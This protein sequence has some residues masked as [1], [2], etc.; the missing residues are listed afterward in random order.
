MNCSEALLDA[1][2]K[3]AFEIGLK[4]LRKKNRRSLLKCWRVEMHLLLLAELVFVVKKLEAV[5]NV[6]HCN[7]WIRKELFKA[8]R[9]DNWNLREF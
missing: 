3:Y 4:P 2:A 7:E 6:L 5:E 8:N 9:S 1:V